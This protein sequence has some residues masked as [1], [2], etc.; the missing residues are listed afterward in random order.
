LS[1]PKIKGAALYS[2]GCLIEHNCKENAHYEIEDDLLYIIAIEHIDANERLSINYIRPYLSKIQ[3]SLFLKEQYGFD[4]QCSMCNNEARD[5]VRSY[6]CKNCENGI[7]TP[8][9]LGKFLNDWSCEICSKG[10]D[11]NYFDE[12]KILEN[13]I[14]ILDDSFTGSGI[15]VDYQIKEGIYHFTHFFIFWSL[16]YRVH[17]ISKIKPI[18]S[19][20]F[21]EL[22][23]TSC[24]RVLPRYHPQKALY[25][26]ILGQINIILSNFEE[27]KENFEKSYMIRKFSCSDQLT[28]TQNA[29]MK[30]D[31]PENTPIT[32]WS[33]Y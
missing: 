15:D 1:Y 5:L 17:T 9:G 8:V 7:V 16:D 26:D 4:C 29:K 23:I 20:K 33:P 27:S 11:E 28:V 18:L 24:N 2:I 14:N 21:L 22:L 12:I 32:L 19:K 3:R 31:D 25:Y 6:K 30:Y 10:I 13:N